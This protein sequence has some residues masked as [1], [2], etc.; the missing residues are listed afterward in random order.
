MADQ[1]IK[2]MF[3]MTSWR[4]RRQWGCAIEVIQMLQ[5]S[6]GYIFRFSQPFA[7][8]PCKNLAML[9]LDRVRSYC[10]GQGLDNGELSISPKSQYNL[11]TS[12]R[13]PQ[14]YHKLVNLAFDK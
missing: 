11:Y 12:R 9:V 10:F 8:N 6:Q 2:Q 3:I 4:A 7:T 1:I 13:L 14:K 5:T